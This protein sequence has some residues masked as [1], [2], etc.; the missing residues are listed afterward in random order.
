MCTACYLR[1][2]EYHMYLKDGATGKHYLI[3]ASNT[4][5]SMCNPFAYYRVYPTPSKKYCDSTLLE[6]HVGLDKRLR[7]K[8]V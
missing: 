8:T 5:F 2:V 1:R 4:E 6:T 3:Y 7:K